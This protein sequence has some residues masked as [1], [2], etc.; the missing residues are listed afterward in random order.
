MAMTDDDLPPGDDITLAPN[1]R[2]GCVWMTVG[3]APRRCIPPS[4]ARDMADQMEAKFDLDAQDAEGYE[5]TD[6]ADRLRKLADDVD[7]TDTDD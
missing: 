7:D 2:D 4:M 1:Y 5:A 6:L 3:N